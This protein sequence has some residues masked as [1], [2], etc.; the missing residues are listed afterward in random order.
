MWLLG[1]IGAVLF[2]DI[3][4]FIATTRQVIKKFRRKL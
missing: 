2:I 4:W 3:M 1:A